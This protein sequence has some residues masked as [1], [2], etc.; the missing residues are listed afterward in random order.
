M[1]LVRDVIRGKSLQNLITVDPS[2]SIVDAADVMKQWDVGALLVMEKDALIGLLTERN[3]VR[4]VLATGRRWEGI[5]VA[6]V[7]TRE[8]DVVPADRTTDECMGLMT[9]LRVRHLPVVW[10]GDVLG[11]VS[12][13]DLVKDVIDDQ[14]WVI[15]Q[16]EAYIARSPT[17]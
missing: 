12:I 6:D 11:I 14:S 4:K 9:H 10:G 8:V 3:L 5:T 7:M 13:G 1:K 17:A 16:L 2:M 15:E